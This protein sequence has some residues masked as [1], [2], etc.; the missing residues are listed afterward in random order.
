VTAASLPTGASG[1]ADVFWNIVALRNLS[2]APGS[3]LDVSV[4][5]TAPG[6]CSNSGGDDREDFGDGV[7]HWHV[8]ASEGGFWSEE[9]RLQPAASSLTTSVTCAVATGLKVGTQPNDAVVGN[10]ITGNAND[11][12]GPP[13]TVDLVDAGGNTVDTSSGSVT[14]ALGNN[15]SGATLGGT[16]TQPVV[17]GVATFNNL[18]LNQPDNGYTLVASSSGLTNVTS[19]SFNENNSATPCPAGQTCTNTLST[20]NSSLQVDVGAGPEPATLTQSVDVGTPMNGDPGCAFYTPPASSVDWYE[21]VVS[22]SDRSKTVTWTVNRTSPAGFRVCYGAPYDFTA[23]NSDGGLQQAA[24]GQMLPDGTLGFVGILP[25]CRQ[26]GDGAATNP[27]VSG[28]TS[29]DSGAT[30][31]TVTIPAGLPGDPWM[32]R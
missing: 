29:T 28:L 31:A 11:T 15:P 25:T 22:Q 19:N 12:S 6:D 18:T 32:G 7:R 3:T 10:V 9:L 5:A 14:I 20:P 1:S 8:F 30:V 4:T 21:F 26:L 27:C 13:V 17:H 2:L 24:G 16:L 23:V